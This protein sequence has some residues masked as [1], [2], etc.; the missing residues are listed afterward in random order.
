MR[1]LILILGTIVLISG[2]VQ[3][4]APVIDSTAVSIYSP[5][6]A[7]LFW[8]TREANVLCK[9][10]YDVDS[11]DD[12]G[13]WS[14]MIAAKAARTEGIQKTL[15]DGTVIPASGDIW[16]SNLHADSTYQYK[17]VFYFS[18]G[19]DGDSATQSGSFTTVNSSD[20]ASIAGGTDQDV[21]ICDNPDRHYRLD[22]DRTATFSGIEI[23]DNIAGI[24]LQG[25]TLWFGDHDSIQVLNFSFETEDGDSEHAAN[26]TFSD[27]TVIKR[28]RGSNLFGWGTLT[29]QNNPN[30]YDGDWAVWVNPARMTDSTVPYYIETTSDITIPGGTDAD[31]FDLYW[32]SV[33]INCT[34]KDNAAANN[35]IAFIQFD[36]DSTYGYN[37]NAE[38]NKGFTWNGHSG[39]ADNPWRYTDGDFGTRGFSMLGFSVRPGSAGITAKLR[40]GFYGTGATP[41]VNPVYGNVTDLWIDVPRIERQRCFGI[42]TPSSTTSGFDSLYCFP[43]AN[44]TYSSHSTYTANIGGFYIVNGTI[45][46]KRNS[47]WPAFMA[48]IMTVTEGGA[49]IDNGNVTMDGLTVT[50]YGEECLPIYRKWEDK[51]SI[52]STTVNDLG[53]GIYC[54]DDWGS[55][56][57]TF[58]YDSGDNYFGYN[59]VETIRQI[60]AHIESYQGAYRDNMYEYNYITMNSYHANSFGMGQAGTFRFN[61]FVSR[62]ENGGGGGTAM[63]VGGA[64]ITLYSNHFESAA[65]AG[66]EQWLPGNAIQFESNGCRANELYN[67]VC[68]GYRAVNYWQTSFTSGIKLTT[69]GDSNY[70]HNNYIR[71][72]DSVTTGNG[73]G[74]GIRWDNDTS[75]TDQSATRFYQN[76][77]EGTQAVYSI[78]LDYYVASSFLTSTE[79]TLVESNVSTA[80]FYTWPIENTNGNVQQDCVFSGGAAKDDIV[81]YTDG[82]VKTTWTITV[83][84]GNDGDSVWAI[85]QHSNIYPGGLTSGG[86]YDIVLPEFSDDFNASYDTTFSPY[87]IYASGGTGTD[88]S[89]YTVAGKATVVMSLAGGSPGD[90]EIGVS[91]GVSFG[92]AVNEKVYVVDSLGVQCTYVKGF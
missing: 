80:G 31:T 7:K 92:S 64:R 5:W 66:Y 10:Y 12:G 8:V 73:L 9:L 55:R 20:T 30:V 81:I 37:N 38:G 72:I 47:P 39:D 42:V 17:M 44:K 3:A 34:P 54:R 71:G 82:N 35:T 70:I 27:T 26:W 74:Y 51:D 59:R 25:D 52:T 41:F 49:G 24:D 4:A 56:A 46:M 58:G 14:N 67:S 62:C 29:D 61:T 65:G 84:T 45:A 15:P 6:S 68:K 79:D 19:G 85:D 87:T 21:Y 13:V 60:G 76:H 33:R 16:A 36:G 90:F 1:R 75:V 11:T 43:P 50:V 2:T 63:Q 40:V 18:G 57:V 23:V 28:N 91:T 32:V 69:I 89:V 78:G 22:G 48:G 86:S 77:I 53:R 88:D 83:Q